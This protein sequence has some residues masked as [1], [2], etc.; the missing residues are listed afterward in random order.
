MTEFETEVLERL[1][2]IAAILA[3]ASRHAVAEVRRQV[4]PDDLSTAILDTCGSDWISGAELRRPVGDWAKR[5]DRTFRACAAEVVAIGAL[6][7]RGR[8]KGARYA[9]TGL[10]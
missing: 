6:R 10:L 1:D 8:T 2:R 9:T 5:G 3:L 4:R 7:R